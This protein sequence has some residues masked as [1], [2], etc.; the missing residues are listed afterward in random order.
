[1]AVEQRS[2]WLFDFGAD[3]RA[4][5][6]G[7]HMAEYLRAPSAI[8]V[9]L[10]PPHA[11]GVLVWRERLVPLLDLARL[12]GAANDRDKPMGA[13][14]LAYRETPASP[15]Q[16]GALALAAAPREI[17][18]RD[19]MACALPTTPVFWSAIAASCIDH[20]NRPT[21]ILRSRNIFTRALAVPAESDAL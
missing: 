5:V 17:E 1:M 21:P 10:A 16:Y 12:A 4:A 7:Q 6:G 18:V 19:E 13:I 15:L 8:E 9:P 2:A 20:E 14:V 3:L 11:R